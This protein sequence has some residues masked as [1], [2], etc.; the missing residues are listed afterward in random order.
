MN[1]SIELIISIWAILKTGASYM[2]MFIEYPRDRLEYM[3]KNSNCTIVITKSIFNN[4]LFDCNIINVDNFKEIHCSTVLPSI[5]ILPDNLAY[6][7]YTSG[8]TGRPK[9]VKITHKCLNNY[10]HS[11]NKLFNS[12]TSDDKLLSST[13]I[14]LFI[15]KFKYPP[16]TSILVI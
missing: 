6:I 11:F 5:S 1:K 14:S 7:I 10:I 13:N 4:V 16:T 12:I 2:P 8:S 9:G 15:K 3:V